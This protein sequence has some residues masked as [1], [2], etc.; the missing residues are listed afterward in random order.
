MQQIESRRENVKTPSPIMNKS[1]LSPTIQKIY[2]EPSPS[3]GKNSLLNRA[4][5]MS[6]SPV[7]KPDPT[8]TE[9]ANLLKEFQY[10]KAQEKKLVEAIQNLKQEV[11]LMTR[12]T[13]KQ[14][15]EMKLKSAKLENEKNEIVDYFVDCVS[16]KL[17]VIVMG[18]ERS[19]SVPDEPAVRKVGDM[20]YRSNSFQVD[21]QKN[22]SEVARLNRFYKTKVRKAIDG[23]PAS[24]RVLARNFNFGE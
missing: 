12:K 1:K 3:L 14:E 22:E 15:S 19:R 13:F 21:L 17:V 9:E 8:K 5:N 20:S 4:P 7:R 10:Y 2:R 16:K 6:P 11:L 18:Q 23:V 24:C